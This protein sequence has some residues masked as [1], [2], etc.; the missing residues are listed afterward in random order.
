MQRV[1]LNNQTG[2]ERLHIEIDKGEIADLLDDV[3]DFDAWP[4]TLAF[5]E[6]LK[7][8]QVLFTARED[9]R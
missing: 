6:I 7:E 5:V 3:N 1:Y 9:S 8:A 4:A 2:R